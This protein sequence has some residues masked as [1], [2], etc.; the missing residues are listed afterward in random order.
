MYNFVILNTC[1]KNTVCNPIKLNI[2]SHK[3]DYVPK[4]ILIHLHG[5]G[6]HFQQDVDCMDTFEYKI[7]KLKDL[8][9]V[10][11]GLELRGHGKSDGLRFHVNRFDE[12]VSD[13][14]T[15][16][17]YLKKKYPL[18]PIYLTGE[19]MGG[20]LAI[21]YSIKYKDNIKG[22][23]LFAPMI[24]I[25]IKIP[26]IIIFLFYIL[27]YILPLW[28]IVKPFSI[29]KTDIFKFKKYNTDCQY[30]FNKPGRLCTTREC[31]SAI[32]WINN[33]IDNFDCAIIIFHSKYD[34]ITSS[35]SS[36]QFIH[37]CKSIDKEYVELDLD[38][39]SLIT[40]ANKYDKN[41]DE[42]YNQ[43]YIWLKKH[44]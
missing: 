13:V 35:N 28:E 14:H 32:K 12:Y 24:G 29:N 3:I 34:K 43:F 21:I 2:V 26:R 39:H 15:L 33:N 4:A 42:I 40:Q 10:S 44:I 8:N 18:I 41:P 27:S 25:D 23:G 11:Y 17:S 16:V 36:K 22:M 30:A 31:F 9:I 19:S 6:C 7:N 20:G 38:T 37:N 1:K 5:I